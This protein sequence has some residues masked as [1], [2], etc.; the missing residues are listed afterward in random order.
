M[1]DITKFFPEKE[2][3]QEIPEDI[4]IPASINK[5]DKG[6]T[7]INTMFGND[8]FGLANYGY[9]LKAFI[10]AKINEGS[11][12]IP[13]TNINL[14]EIENLV[15]TNVQDAI[16]ELKQ[17]SYFEI[18]FGADIQNF[19][20]PNTASNTNIENQSYLNN[21]NLLSGFTST[22]PGIVV[23]NTGKTIFGKVTLTISALNTCS[24]S[25]N[26]TVRIRRNNSV[27]RQISGSVP[28]ETKANVVVQG[29]VSLA[30][31]DDLR[32]SC[33]ATSGTDC[34]GFAISDY[35]LIFDEIQ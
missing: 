15:A 26:Y 33:S 9:S 28:G 24:D 32:A 31:G 20:I 18:G 16:A 14:T 25:I 21:N 35:S 10:E 1:S 11:I 7:R 34:E 6:S 17:R 3:F 13:A 19:I 30:N 4:I 2:S 29:I 27:Y 23:N 12:N 5:I 8:V 22:T